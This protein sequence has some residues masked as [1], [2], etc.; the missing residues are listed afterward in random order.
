M[1]ARVANWAFSQ[2]AYLMKMALL[3]CLANTE[4]KK[5]I[6]GNLTGLKTI[7]DNVYIFRLRTLKHC[8]N[9]SFNSI[10]TLVFFF[11]GDQWINAYQP[12]IEFTIWYTQIQAWIALFNAI[13]SKKMLAPSS[14]KNKFKKNSRISVEEKE[15][16]HPSEM[17]NKKWHLS[18]NQHSSLLWLSKQSVI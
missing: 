16:N 14:T 11:L 18:K 13:L 10:H 1:I 3:N 17:P 9:K 7:P 12:T 15:V 4:R 8:L 6:A 2:I 5:N